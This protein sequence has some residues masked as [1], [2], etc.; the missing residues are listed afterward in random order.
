VKPKFKGLATYKATHGDGIEIR[1]SL[2]ASRRIP[3]I[4]VERSAANINQ[5]FG[6]GDRPR[7]DAVIIYQDIS[8]GRRQPVVVTLA[9]QP[10]VQSTQVPAAV[11]SEPKDQETVVSAS[12]AGTSLVEIKR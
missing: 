1:G 12:L 7:F 3:G 6:S 2:L 4:P 5:T 11:S 8:A 10:T 9:P